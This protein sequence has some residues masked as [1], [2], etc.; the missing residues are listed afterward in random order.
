MGEVVENENRIWGASFFIAWVG[1]SISAL[2]ER[3]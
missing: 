1:R 2:S 3:P